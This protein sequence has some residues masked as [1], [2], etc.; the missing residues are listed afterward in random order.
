MNKFG[1]VDLNVAYFFLPNKIAERE[2]RV[3]SHSSL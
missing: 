1:W 3:N 2:E